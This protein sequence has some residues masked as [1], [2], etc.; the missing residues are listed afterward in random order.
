MLNGGPAYRRTF[1]P[2][3]RHDP[4]HIELGGGSNACCDFES[5]VYSRVTCDRSKG[6]V[7]LPSCGAPRRTPR[8]CLSIQ[9]GQFFQ[10]PGRQIYRSQYC[11]RYYS[12]FSNT[13]RLERERK[14]S[15]TND[16]HTKRHGHVSRTYPSTIR[17]IRSPFLGIL[18]TPRQ[19]KGYEVVTNTWAAKRK[20]ARMAVSAGRICRWRRISELLN[21]GYFET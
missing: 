3:A 21:R 19:R 16:A 12:R 14:R 6:V 20:R 13:N 7:E 1:S 10:G 17:I 2:D 4:C 9:A 15:N 8:Q 18:Q 5:P 11:C